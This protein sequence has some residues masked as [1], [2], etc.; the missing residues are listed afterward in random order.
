MRGIRTPLRIIFASHRSSDIRWR[1]IGDAQA[2]LPELKFS[3]EVSKFDRIAYLFESEIY[4][5]PRVNEAAMLGSISRRD[6]VIFDMD[7]MYNPVIRLDG[8]DFNHVSEADQA[9]WKEYYRGAFR[10]RDEADA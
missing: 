3:R 8:Y 10:P 6:R 5:L 4:R 2:H 7:G 1:C 9:Q